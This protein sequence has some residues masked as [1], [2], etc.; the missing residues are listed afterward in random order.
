MN[1]DEAVR[2]FW[3]NRPRRAIGDRKIA[4]VASGIGHRYGIDPILVRVAFAVLT[5]YGG[6]GVLLYLLG[7]VLLANENDQV[8]AFEAMTGRG[9][10]STSVVV[11]VLLCLAM[12]PVSGWVFGGVS[13]LVALTL[14]VG[15]LYLL[16]RNRSGI[17]ASPSA[18][19]PPGGAAAGMAS[20]SATSRA[21]TSE[22]AARGAASGADAFAPPSGETAGA[23]QAHEGGSNPPTGHSSQTPPSWDPLGAAPFAWDLPEPSPVAHPATP[24]RPRNHTITPLTVALAVIAAGAC[25]LAR[26]FAGWFSLGHSLGVVLA[27]VGLGMVLGSL[28]HGGRGLFL[29]AIPL[30]A[31]TVALTLSHGAGP[32]G[33]GGPFDHGFGDTTFAPNSAEQVR[34]SYGVGAGTLTLDLTRLP[35]NSPAVATSVNVGVGSARIMLPPNADVDAHCVAGL[36]DVDCLGQHTSG[37]SHAIDVHNTGGPGGAQIKLNV[38]A[39]T[40][41]VEVTRG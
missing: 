4:G 20:P 11:T 28:L 29:P 35:P 7:W 32:I 1:A 36:G 40:G 39:G 34:P 27:V 17:A 13:G 18:A 41:N 37:H 14:G 12:I 16:H 2:E 23:E 15:S 9:R 33:I 8:S 3:A 26:P 25:A 30:A 31:A 19:V 21:A 24:A 10:S 5:F 6:A 38:Q 22:A